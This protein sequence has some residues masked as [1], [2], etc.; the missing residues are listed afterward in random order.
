MIFGK[1]IK[2]K[3]SYDI[4]SWILQKITALIIGLYILIFY[5]YNIFQK[6]EISLQYIKKIINKTYFKILI[7]F[8]LINIIIHILFGIYD[9]FI[10]YL[11]N[12]KILLIFQ[13]LF[14]I[15]IIFCINLIFK[16]LWKI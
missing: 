13:L 10:D 15:W 3:F 11:K 14:L 12:K 4:K 9:I 7:I 8:L 1:K 6:K 5:I 2:N 16:I